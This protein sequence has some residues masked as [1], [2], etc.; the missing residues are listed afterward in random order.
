MIRCLLFDVDDTLM[1]YHQ[2]EM[3]IL[4]RIFAENG[5]VPSQAELDDLWEKSWLYWNLRGLHETWR[6]EIQRDYVRLYRNAVTDYCAYM[7]RK[8]D[9][10]QDENAL[11]ELFGRYLGEAVTLYDDVLPVLKMLKGYFVLCAASNALSDCQRPRLRAMGIRFD[12]IF[13]SEEMG[14]IKPA[15]AFFRK[16]AQAAG[17]ETAE[18]MMVGDS[19]SSD[20]AGAQKAGMKTCWINRAGRALSG[21]IRPDAVIQ[22][23][24]QLLEIKE[25]REGFQND[26]I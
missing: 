21:E 1:D 11:Y 17:C 22:N 18:C 4:R 24:H 2:A 19:L 23:L 16:A 3:Q 20:I 26:R 14:T 12:H 15:Q 6:E 10:K 25:I 8:Y 13:L 5:K 7:R 9:L